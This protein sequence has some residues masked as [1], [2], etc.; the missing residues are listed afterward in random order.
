ME[1]YDSSEESKYIAYLGANSLHGWAMSQYLL[2]NGFKW[3]NQ[4]EINRFGVK[5]IDEN[6]CIGYI[7]QVDLE[8]PSESHKLDIDYPLAPEKFQISICC[9]NIVL[10]LRVN[11]KWWS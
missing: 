6:S 1:C 9:Q 10:I 4:K 7:L 8:Y 3:L 2:Y 11:K 5:S